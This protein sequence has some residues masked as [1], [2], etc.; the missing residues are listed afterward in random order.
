MVTFWSPPVQL[1]FVVLFYFQQ[2]SGGFFTA[3]M[4]VLCGGLDIYI[5]Y[6]LCFLGLKVI[7]TLLTQTPT[8][9]VNFLFTF[10]YA[11]FY[12]L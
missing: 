6:N 7:A 2:Y 5:R 3:K 8:P 1:E 11:W 10:L 4:W 9:Q 12:L